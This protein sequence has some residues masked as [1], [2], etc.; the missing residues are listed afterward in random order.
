[1]SMDIWLEVDTGGDEPRRLDSDDPGNQ[2][3]N[4]D[5][6]F[7]LALDGDAAAGI[8][9]GHDLLIARKGPSLKRFEGLPAG[10]CVAELAAAVARMEATPE[11]YRAL[12]PA[13]GWGSY[14]GA[15]A[16]LQRFRDVC[17]ANPAARVAM[18]L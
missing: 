9:N 6:M 8:Q 1:M 7:A 10:D 14:E 4:V 11:S 13:N 2:T 16:Y 5:P 17:A 3:Y 18:W 12:N 15:L